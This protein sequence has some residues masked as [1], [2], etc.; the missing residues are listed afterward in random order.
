MPSAEDK[1]TADWRA[2]DR[3]AMG[4]LDHLGS[5]DDMDDFDPAI[6]A[7]AF[8]SFDRPGVSTERYTA[9]LDELAASLIEA[10][11]D[12]LVD[13]ALR[14]EHLQKVLAGEFGYFGDDLT[15][16]DLQNANIMRVID[17]RRGLPVA[18]GILYIAAA[19]RAGWPAFGL[20]FPGHFLIRV[21]GGGGGEGRAILDPFN[22][23]RMV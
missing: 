18:L 8:A 7:I 15:Y 1:G 12:G 20:N 13:A 17:R 5:L 16:D 23:G 14:A 19:Q 10:D 4:V 11:M 9:H 2:I 6:A 22:G 3:D 21:D